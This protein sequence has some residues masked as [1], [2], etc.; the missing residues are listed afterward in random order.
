[1]E[2]VKAAGAQRGRKFE[3]GVDPKITFLTSKFLT[4]MVS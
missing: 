1:M 3:D 2:V 4:D